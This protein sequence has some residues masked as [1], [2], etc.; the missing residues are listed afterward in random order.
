[1]E[2]EFQKILLRVLAIGF[3]VIGGGT[4]ALYFAFRSFE[5]P[6]GERGF[7]WLTIIGFGVLVICAVLWRLSY[8]GQ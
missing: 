6:G 5:K 8:A 3:V 4:V 2:P 1:M 7:L